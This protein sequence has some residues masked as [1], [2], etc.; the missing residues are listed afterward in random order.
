MRNLG[1]DE[2]IER[3]RKESM[4]KWNMEIRKRF[5]AVTEKEAWQNFTKGL[6]WFA[7]NRN[8]KVELS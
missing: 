3:S 7:P 4:E 8:R 6:D 2:A 5:F 1:V